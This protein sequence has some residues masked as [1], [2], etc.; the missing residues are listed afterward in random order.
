[1]SSGERQ[2]KKQAPHGP[3][4]PIGTNPRR[5]HDPSQTLNGLSHPGVSKIV[6][7]KDFLPD[8]FDNIKKLTCIV[9]HCNVFLFNSWESRDRIA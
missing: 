4:S 7:L 5:D 8:F 6:V 1:M 3:R 2:R 9:C